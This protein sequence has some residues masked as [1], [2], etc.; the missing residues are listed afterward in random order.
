M[1][2]VQA[3]HVRAAIWRKPLNVSSVQ[4]LNGSD[5]FVDEK[6]YV[7]STRFTVQTKGKVSPVVSR[8]NS[9]G[10]GLGEGSTHRSRSRD[11]D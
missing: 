7:L 4:L 2:S 10:F 3:A 6:I 9:I 5:R 8:D 11:A 1:G